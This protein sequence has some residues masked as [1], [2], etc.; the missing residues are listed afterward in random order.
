M[1]ENSLLLN[2]MSLPQNHILYVAM[3]VCREVTNEISVDKLIKKI[4]KKRKTSGNLHDEAR[5]LKAIG[6]L[7]ALG[8]VNYYRG[9]I[10]P[11]DT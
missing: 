6:A 1:K 9:H 7:I 2:K 8:K 4:A 5:I 3:Q 11:S 10:L